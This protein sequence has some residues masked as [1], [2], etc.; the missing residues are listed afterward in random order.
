M[1]QF[2][3]IHYKIKVLLIKKR[4]LYLIICTVKDGWASI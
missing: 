2:N 3:I 4:V 1:S